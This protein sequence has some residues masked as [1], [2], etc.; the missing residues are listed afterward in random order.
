MFG[1]GNFEVVTVGDTFKTTSGGTPSSKVLEYY[2]GGSIPWLTSGEV[3]QGVIK[4]VIGR[5]TEDGL[6]NSSAKIVPSNSV[7]VAMYGAIAGKVGLLK[8]SSTTN[9]AVCTILPPQVYA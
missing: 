5:I 3:N 7:V 1:D 6:K 4:S 2:E 8:I 9:Q